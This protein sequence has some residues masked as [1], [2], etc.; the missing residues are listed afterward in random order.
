M[1]C[2]SCGQP[3]DAT[4]CHH[5]EGEP[6]LDGRY[7]LLSSLGEGATGTTWAA[8]GPSGPVAIKE[9]RLS[10]TRDG[11][12]RELFRREAAVLRQLNHPRIPRWVEDFE[13]R[14]GRHRTLFVVQERVEGETL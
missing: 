5:C 8:D 7:R 1:H 14:T 9:L 10:A 2:A 11:K 4:P 13:L 6:R 12:Q 3:T